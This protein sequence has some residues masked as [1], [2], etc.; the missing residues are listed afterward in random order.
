[1]VQQSSFAEPARRYQ[2][3]TVIVL[4]LSPE[5]FDFIAAIGEIGA[6][7]NPSIFKGISHLASQ[8]AFNVS[9]ITIR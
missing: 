6:A 2:E 1:M 3:N 4:H 5:L 7:D 9:L 8:Y